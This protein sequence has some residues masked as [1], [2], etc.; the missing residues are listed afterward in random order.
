MIETKLYHCTKFE[1]LKAILKDMAFKPSYCLEPINYLNEP[2]SLAF[3]MVCFADLM[4]VEVAEHMKIF[5]SD[6]YLQMN[7]DWARRNGLSNVIYYGAKTNSAF[8]FREIFFEGA[9]KL[10]E[11]NKVLDNFT[12]GASLLMA[13]IKPYKGH[14][15]D[16]SIHNWSKAETQFYNER[17]WRFIP[18]TQNKEHF[19]LDEKDYKNDDYR[20]E[21]LNN[22]NKNPKNLLHFTLNDI[23]VIGVKNIDEVNDIEAFIKKIQLQQKNSATPMIKLTYN[24]NKRQ[25]FRNFIT[26]IIRSLTAKF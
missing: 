21:C 25:Q 4:D 20:N 13:L 26:E 5:H 14:C 2:M 7:K 19:Y 15:W 3:P 24:G 6:C 1:S 12:I 17:E 22:L 9:K 11:K 10:Q 16:K 23:E 18:I 8:A